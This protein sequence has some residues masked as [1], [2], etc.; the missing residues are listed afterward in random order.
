M[1]KWDSLF[2]VSAVEPVNETI[3]LQ[4]GVSPS[5]SFFNPVRSSNNFTAV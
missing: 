3:T 5:I 4:T 1:S 2:D